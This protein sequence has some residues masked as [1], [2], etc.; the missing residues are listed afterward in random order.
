MM[1]RLVRRQLASYLLEEL[2]G[3]QRAGIQEHLDRCPDCARACDLLANHIAD[4]EEALTTDIRAPFDLQE[5]IA[6]RIREAAP[7]VPWVR[8][9]R[10][11]AARGPA[12]AARGSLLLVAALL[13]WAGTRFAGRGSRLWA[14]TRTPVS[15]VAEGE[16]PGRHREPRAASRE[17]PLAALVADHVEYL[18]KPSPAEFATRDAR[19]AAVY[20]G[21]RLGYPVAPVDLSP[22][23]ATLLGGRKCELQGV[24]VAFLFY[25]CDGTRLSLYQLDTRLARLPGLAPVRFHG[26]DYRAGQRGLGGDR[27]PVNL[28]AWQSGGMTFVL[29]ADMEREALLRIA[30]CAAV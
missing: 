1:C 24:P 20:L 18:A 7:T 4:L 10:R 19:A 22:A 5:R 14:P 15:H 2:T 9:R 28:V 6:A 11:P 17:L 8:R 25:D 29:V 27:R 13:L 30:D 3:A 21:R 26:H 12:L 23:G 16:L